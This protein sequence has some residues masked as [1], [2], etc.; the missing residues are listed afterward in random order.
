[1]TKPKVG[2]REIVLSATRS[3]LNKL[4][5][6]VQ[7]ACGHEHWVAQRSRPTGRRFCVECFVVSR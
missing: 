5:W 2:A 7:L 6:L 4:R 1:M 3:P